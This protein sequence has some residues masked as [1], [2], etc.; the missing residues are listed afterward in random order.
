MQSINNSPS[1][2]NPTLARNQLK[3]IRHL[4]INA[5]H[6]NQAIFIA[7]CKY[8]FVALRCPHAAQSVPQPGLGF[9]SMFVSSSDTLLPTHTHTHPSTCTSHESIDSQTHLQMGLIPLLPATTITH[10]HTHIGICETT[11]TPPSHPFDRVSCVCVYVSA[12]MFRQGE[13][14]K[15]AYV[16]IKF[17]SQVAGS[18]RTR[19]R[20]AG[21]ST[22]SLQ[23]HFLAGWLLS[24][25]KQLLH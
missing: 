21:R 18:G 4:S 13:E 11:G 25:R 8:W 14:G 5:S 2:Q 1:L 9:G 17:S 15:L 23:I 24:L 16:L 12:G 7:N 20:S 19:T 22:L 10:T 6:T 3:T